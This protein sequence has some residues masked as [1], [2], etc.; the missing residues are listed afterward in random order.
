MV[1][2]D[3]FSNA[4]IAADERSGG[5]GQNGICD[6]WESPCGAEQRFV[7]VPV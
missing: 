4:G 3:W 6:I 1:V 5:H 2:V 7:R